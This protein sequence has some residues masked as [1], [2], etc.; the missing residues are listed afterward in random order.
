MGFVSPLIIL[1]NESD[2]VTQRHSILILLLR[3]PPNVSAD[4]EMIN[5]NVSSHFKMKGGK[6]FI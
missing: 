3:L 4:T 5:I 2:T 1:L 6:Y